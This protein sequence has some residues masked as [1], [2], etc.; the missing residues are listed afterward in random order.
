MKASGESLL[1]FTILPL[2]EKC[3][4]LRLVSRFQPRGLAGIFYWYALLPFH[5]LISR[6]MLSWILRAAGS[7]ALKGPVRW[8]PTGKDA[9]FPP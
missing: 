4:E 7:R 8:Q 2:G 6:G 9:C 1:D 5:R 3:C